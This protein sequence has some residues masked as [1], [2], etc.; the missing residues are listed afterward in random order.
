MVWRSTLLTDVVLVL[1]AV[2]FAISIGAH[3]TGACMGM[4]H[5]L[6]AVTKRQALLLMAPLALLGAALASHPVETTVA[7]HL[8][9]RRL[10]LTDEIVVIAL[11]FAL[12]SAYN[13]IKLPT[14]T[15][16]L[17]VFSLVGVALGDGVGV[18]WGTLILLLA[19]WLLAPLVAALLGF[20]FTRGI[21]L[22]NPPSAVDTH[23]QRAG[24]ARAAAIGLVVVGG[25]ASFTMGAND[26]SNATGSLVAT[27]I[28]DPLV[29]GVIGG[30]GLAVGV[31]VWGG[32]LLKRVAFDIVKVDQ[33]MALAAQLVQ[34]LVV[35]TAV[36]F[37]LFTSM[38]QALVGAMTGAGLARGQG[39]IDRAVLQG[40]ING[41]IAG[42]S[43][44]LVLGL[45]LGRLTFV[46]R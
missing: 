45:L 3:Y 40:I 18:V 23:P 30:L 5:A 29:A 1:L 37:G 17:L 11:A 33:S 39:S 25:V 34:A 46:L 44:A 38:N 12:T 14:S 43:S 28:A 41:W 10:D 35:L 2:G 9:S 7:L 27:R 21:D 32:P 4:P 15:I 26:V 31:L 19:V 36:A 6:G 24:A 16:Q 20:C 22:V 42:P 13:R 8:T